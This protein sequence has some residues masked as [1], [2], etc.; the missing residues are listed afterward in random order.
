MISATSVKIVQKE[1]WNKRKCLELKEVRV[2]EYSE[3]LEGN[4][5]I[6]IQY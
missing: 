1:K 5:M 3:E 6:I 4:I 2:Y